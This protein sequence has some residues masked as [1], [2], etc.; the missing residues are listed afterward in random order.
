VPK[1]GDKRKLIEMSLK[2]SFSLKKERK[3]KEELPKATFAV[4]QLKEGLSLNYLTP[5]Y[6][7]F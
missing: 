1:I 5:T 6:R 7:M 4:Q 2:N 3:A